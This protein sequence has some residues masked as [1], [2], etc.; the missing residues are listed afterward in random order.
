M[1]KIGD[2][3]VK[4]QQPSNLH[5]PPPVLTATMFAVTLALSVAA[6]ANTGLMR[7]LVT[8]LPRL[9]SGQWWRLVTPVFVQPSGWGQLIFNVLGIAIIGI[10]LQRRLGWAG[11]LLTYL[12][13]GSGTIALYILWHPGDTGDG[14]SS[15]AVAAMIGAVGVLMVSGTNL[16]RREWYAQLYA[17]F[18][19]AYLTALQLGGVWPSIAAGDVSVALM[20]VAHHAASPVWVCRTSL[21]I[22]VLAGVL[23]TAMRNDHGAGILIGVVIGFL[24]LAHRHPWTRLS[25]TAGA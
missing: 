25:E 2:L 23:M 9:R 14:G 21:G 16:G 6:I 18:F 20:V 22:V 8:D 24:T 12:A 7:L 11:W 17:V 5:D 19:A 13:G 10:A 15:A 3:K 4:P 1:S